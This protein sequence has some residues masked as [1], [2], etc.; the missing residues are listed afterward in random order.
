MGMGM[1]DFI[2]KI[3]SLKRE[4]ELLGLSELFREKV[5]HTYQRVLLDE[6]SAIVSENISEEETIENLKLILEKNWERIKGSLVCYTACPEDELTLLLCD[7]AEHISIKK[8]QDNKSAINFLMPT[9]KTESIQDNY[10][11]LAPDDAEDQIPDLRDVLKTHILSSTT[12]YLIPVHLFCDYL[13]LPLNSFGKLPNCYFDFE[14]M[15]EAELYVNENEHY[16]LLNHSKDTLALDHWKTQI[17]I[18]SQSNINLLSRLN[19][20]TQS[21]YFNSVNGTGTETNAGDGTYPAIIRF[22]DYYS[23][24]DKE[25][26]DAVPASV[27]RELN[28]LLT[29]S[30]DANENIN[31][32]EN[33]ETCIAI[34]REE[35]VSVINKNI[36]TLSTIDIS[37][38]QKNKLFIEAQSEFIN[39]QKTLKEN[40]E[41][42]NYMGCDAMGITHTLLKC[43]Q[44]ELDINSKL[45]LHNFM[46]L[47]E[48]EIIIICKTKKDLCQK[49][50]KLLSNVE[51]FVLFVIETTPGRLKALL[52]FISDELSDILIQKSSDISACLVALA[53]E[54]ME[55]I[56]QSLIANKIFGIINNSRDFNLLFSPLNMDQRRVVFDSLKNKFNAIIKSSDDLN[57]VLIYLNDEQKTYVYNQIKRR[58]PKMIK[59]TYD[60]NLALQFLTPTLRSMMFN[61][62]KEKILPMIMEKQGYIANGLD[63][64]LEYLQIEQCNYICNDLLKGKMFDTIQCATGF[65]TILLI[66][67]NE[68]RTLIFNNFKNEL[69]KIIK[70]PADF[71]KVLCC[72]NSE[73]RTIVFNEQRNN[74]Y[75]MIMGGWFDRTTTRSN[76]LRD[77]LR[78]LNLEQCK[79]VCNDIIQSKLPGIILEH[80]SLVRMLSS[81]NIKKCQIVCKAIKNNLATTGISQNWRDITHNHQFLALP[82][83]KR[84]LVF[85]MLEEVKSQ[86]KRSRTDFLDGSADENESPRKRQMTTSCVI[87]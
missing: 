69:H 84:L 29:L 61:D 22:N 10:P 24:L 17:E 40:I 38:E 72:L 48:E 41:C 27:K 28:T 45:D 57:N 83:S 12:S 56:Y 4:N 58:L 33:I 53:G 25:Q 74:L 75:T 80:N 31:A 60:F 78:H 2:N 13:T 59:N 54:R 6:L 67:N 71:R 36:S 70:S 85:N 82:E 16:R 50:I 21:L 23:Q 77:V 11:S 5:I 52:P 30:S 43:L 37:D 51:F 32:T 1:L 7:I 81:L 34:R 44:I 9:I 49:I 87:S 79:I 42:K 76:R 55:I 63:V 47:S 62:F 3:A 8:K 14:T 39:A 86:K 65:Y 19:E 73:Q 15:S 46:T 18:L 68:K 20:L 64:L 26:L 66:L 35:L